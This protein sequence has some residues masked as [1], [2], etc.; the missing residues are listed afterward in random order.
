[1]RTI[2]NAIE[3]N[4]A[5]KELEGLIEGSA[6]R[7][8]AIRS[9]IVLGED[10]QAHRLRE[11]VE[12]RNF[13]LA[14]MVGEPRGSVAGKALGV[15]KGRIAVNYV[16]AIFGNGIAEGVVAREWRILFPAGRQALKASQ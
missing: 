8:D 1:M 9:P 11:W 13:D 15:G 7:L 14:A 5:R 3:A 4:K 6:E 10:C 12:T 2:H 16:L